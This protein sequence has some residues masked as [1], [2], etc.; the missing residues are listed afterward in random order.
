MS[1]NESCFTY[2]M[3]CFAAYNSPDTVKIR[4]IVQKYNIHNSHN[5][6]TKYTIFTQYIQQQQNLVFTRMFGEANR[7]D[8]FFAN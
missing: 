2:H 7:V 8:T 5:S 1:N 6:Q 3:R 4:N